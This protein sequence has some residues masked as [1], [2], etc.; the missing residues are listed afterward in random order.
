M[1]VTA[2]YLAAPNGRWRHGLQ[3]DGA[4]SHPEVHQS[5]G[6]FPSAA[7]YRQDPDVDEVRGQNGQVV[8]DGTYVTIRRKGFIA[9]NTIGKGEKRI[10]VGSI[11]SVQWKPASAVFRGFIQFETA[12]VGGTRSRAGSQTHDALRDE[13]SVVFTKPQMAAFAALRAAVEQALAERH[14][15]QRMHQQPA[16]SIADEL[17]KLAALMQQGVI[18][19]QEFDEQKARLLGGGR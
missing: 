7:A 16:P 13:N 9:R 18:S 19:R 4:P 10:P 11:V 15:P 8:F 5:F 12:G 6:Q 14:N 2:T 3:A 1:S 17:A